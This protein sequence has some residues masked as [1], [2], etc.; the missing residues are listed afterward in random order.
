MVDKFCI[1]KMNLNVNESSAYKGL[2]CVELDNRAMTITT[3]RRKWFNKYQIKIIRKI[4]KQDRYL[5]SR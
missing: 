4:I 3:F 2:S 5:E 1:E